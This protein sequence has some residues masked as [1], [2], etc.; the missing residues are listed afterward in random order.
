M[1]GRGAC[2]LGPWGRGAVVLAGAVG[3][4]VGAHRARLPSEPACELQRPGTS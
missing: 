1:T 4:A 3:L 2:Q